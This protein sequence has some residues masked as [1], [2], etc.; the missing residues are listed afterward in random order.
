MYLYFFILVGVETAFGGWIPSFC[1]L[2]GVANEQQA[3]VSSSLFWISITIGRMIAI[4]VATKYN[5]ISQLRFLTYSVFIVL[6]FCMIAILSGSLHIAVYGGSV[7]FGL[8][9]SAIY[10]LLITTPV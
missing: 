10:P 5:G 3:G 4:P 2:T 8:A 9:V 7:M 6:C 1:A